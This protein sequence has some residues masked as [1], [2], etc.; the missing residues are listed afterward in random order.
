MALPTFLYSTKYRPSQHWETILPVRQLHSRPRKQACLG[1]KPA[2]R[3]GNF[4]S[5]SRFRKISITSLEKVKSAFMP[6]M[7]PKT[8]MVFLQMLLLVVYRRPLFQILKDPKLKP[9]STMTNL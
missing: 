3:T 6:R 5:N 8:G 9:T 2:F 7:A 1:E 4:Y